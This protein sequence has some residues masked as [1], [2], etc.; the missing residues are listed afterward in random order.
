MALYNRKGDE[1]DFDNGDN[2][3]LDYRELGEESKDREEDSYEDLY[4]PFVGEDVFD[5]DGNEVNCPYCGEEI[6]WVNG[7]YICPQCKTTMDRVRFFEFI[8]ADNT[9]D[10]CAACPGNYPACRE[11]CDDNPNP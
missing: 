1:S 2:N 3:G 11:W 10:R 8:G 4:D 5:E 6:R 7:T 9:I